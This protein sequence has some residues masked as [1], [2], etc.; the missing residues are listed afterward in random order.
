MTRPIL[1]E[2][3][4][5]GW[6]LVPIPRG[7][8]GPIRPDWQ[9]SRDNCVTDPD[10]AAQL[11]ENVGL[12]HAYS[13]T[14]AIDI[15]DFEASRQWLQERGVDLN[16]LWNAPD[17]VRISS[18]RPN[19]GKLLYRLAEPL[20]SKKIT[21]GKQNVL[22]FRSST[23]TNTTVQDVL[24]PSIHPETGKPYVWEYADDSIGDWRCLPEIPESLHAAWKKLIT[25]Q[26]VSASPTHTS[27]SA[28]N[29]GAAR[30]MLFDHDPNMPYDEWVKVGMALHHASK[31]GLDG[32]DLWNEWSARSDKYKG[33]EDLDS[34]WRSFHT[35]ASN[36]V[37]IN[38][39]RIDTAAEVE[40]F[41]PVTDEMVAEAQVPAA[42]SPIA[43]KEAM[44]QLRRDKMGKALAI[45]PN[46]MPILSVP[47][48]CG[49]R[50]AYDCFKDV[51]AC[52]P[53][54]TDNWR[55]IKDTDYT[56]TRLWLENAANFLPVSKELV[57]DTIHYVAETH[58]MDT[59]QNWLQSLKWDGI[60]RIKN[61]L[62]AYMGTIS[63][64]YEQAVGEYLWTALAGR[65]MEPGCQV[66]MAVI[67]IGA[68]GVGKS[69]GV[70]ALVPGP[71]YYASIRLG[72]KDE[73]I[74]RKIRGVLVG[75]IAELQGFQTTD[76]ERIKEFMTRTHEKWV[77]KWN[78][79][80][81]TFPRRIVFIATTNEDDF[82]R[83]DENR[84]WLPVRTA[85]V[86]VEGIKRDREQ[87][88]A[89][90]LQMWMEN[91]VS[92]YGAQQLATVEQT[93]F[94]VIDN[95]TEIV[96][97]WIAEHP[98]EPHYRVNDLLLQAVGLD[99]RHVTRIH[100]MRVSKIMKSLGYK[101]KTKRDGRK[102]F[103]A[104]VLDSTKPKP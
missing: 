5:A 76:L 32:L 54:G 23:R 47:E 92:W 14:C 31:G 46:L 15:D 6:A 26:A 93:E 75:E 101:S 30:R 11:D 72:D 66:D 91:G 61:F 29:L 25:P 45:L 16:A 7:R 102:I 44:N 3:A 51:L 63:T 83:D 64:P 20:C 80:A 13:G 57:R 62:P 82:L 41:E 28:H 94:K 42:R 99:S 43:I 18:G 90:A 9:E 17:A 88:W 35:D 86:D 96:E 40:E 19:R 53:L 98:D 95:W 100:E 1:A 50:I 79:F 97:R 24:P 68:Q 77:P 4:R 22:E 104:W 27:A 74:A 12:C 81:T 60:P 48:I 2:Y 56:A 58:Q 103:R 59:A 73:D 84:R 52:A 78:E 89:E 70:Q 87:L 36:P 21:R 38:S 85:G 37:T 8:K 39:L 71:E 33:R 10:V 55:P 65:V 69:R 49:Q 67:L 34:H